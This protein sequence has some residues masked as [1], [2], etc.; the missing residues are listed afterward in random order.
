M[1]LVIIHTGK[2]Q[3]IGIGL[4]VA[5]WV[6]KDLKFIAHLPE[7]KNTIKWIYTNKQMNI[8]LYAHLTQEQNKT[9]TKQKQNKTQN[10]NNN[11]NKKKNKQN[12]N[13]NKTKHHHQQQ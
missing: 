8:V 10:N 5:P 1:T 9:T 3:L 6:G 2:E 12:K 11:N 13:Q 4:G 7:G